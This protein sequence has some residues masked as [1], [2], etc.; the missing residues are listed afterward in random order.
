MMKRHESKRSNRNKTK[1]IAFCGVF[2]ALAMIFSYI[3]SFINVPIGIPGFK[4][5]IANMV[6]IVLL[7]SIGSIEALI[8]NIVRIILTSIL[9]GNFTSF[10]FSI[11]GGLLSIIIMILVKRTK[12]FSITGISISGAVSH[13]IGQIIAAVF[14]MENVA[15][16]LI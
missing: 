8:V 2:T 6:I 9:F 4:L 3:E 7:I 14:I 15:I 5:G 10:M 16:L 13:N 11:S 12:F 1:V